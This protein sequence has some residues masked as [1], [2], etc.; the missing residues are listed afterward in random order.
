M[1]FTFSNLPGDLNAS[2]LNSQGYAT[3]T[4]TLSGTPSVAD[5]GTH[6]VSIQASNGVGVTAQQTL[7]LKILAASPTPAGAI[8]ATASG[9][10]YSR[11]TQTFNGTVTF[12]NVGNSTING[13][14]LVVFSGLQ[15]NV[16]LVDQ[17]GLLNNVPY[18]SVAVT[19]LA[20]GQSGSASVQFKNPSSV[21]I[22]FTPVI[23]SG[24][25][26]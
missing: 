21:I 10:S 8:L 15:E 7:S 25:S 19:S 4:L 1:Y 11:V 23:Y 22:N 14:L 20:P 6:Q 13:P 24:A 2:Y 9:L 26:N 3:G 17:S 5:V 18:L 16:S 12:K